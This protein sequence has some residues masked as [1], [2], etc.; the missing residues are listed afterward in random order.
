M[1]KCG[2]PRCAVLTLLAKVSIAMNSPALQ[3]PVPVF[4]V[5]RRQRE[6]LE[7]CGPTGREWGVN[8][9]G[10]HSDETR[11]REGRGTGA[12]LTGTTPR[13]EWL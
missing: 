8:P 11:H 10:L 2:R 13:T 7:G 5:T 6:A 9:V 3:T 1:V 4:S 12:P